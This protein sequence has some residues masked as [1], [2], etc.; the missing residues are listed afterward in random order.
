VNQTIDDVLAG[1]SG[2][3]ET[4]QQKYLMFELQG[5]ISGEFTRIGS[6]APITSKNSDISPMAKQGKKRKGRP[7][8]F[9]IVLQSH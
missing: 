5:S 9:Q 7:D 6:E 2:R 8:P 1:L 4:L 3:I